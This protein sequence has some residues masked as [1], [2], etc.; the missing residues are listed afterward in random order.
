MAVVEPGAFSVVISPPPHLRSEA[1]EPLR[2]D[3]IARPASP[4][5]T[6]AHGGQLYRGAA[7]R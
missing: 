2:L 1:H 7:K 3:P 6:E 5:I 4:L